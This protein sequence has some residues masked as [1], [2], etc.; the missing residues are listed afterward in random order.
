MLRFSEDVAF[1]L[2]GLC[3]LPHPTPLLLV[4][5]D[6]LK[7]GRPVAEWNCT[8]VRAS[9]PHEPHAGWLEFWRNG[10]MHSCPAHHYPKDG[11]PYFQARVGIGGQEGTVSFVSGA[12]FGRPQYTF[13]RYT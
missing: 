1:V 4:G 7:T 13:R 3:L 8:G 10:V 12:P 5:Q 6:V 11:Q 2:H 9:P